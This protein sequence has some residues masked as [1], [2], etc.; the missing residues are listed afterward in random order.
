[1]L[2]F[3]NFCNNGGKMTI[4]GLKLPVL[5]QVDAIEPVNT[6]TRRPAGSFQVRQGA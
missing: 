4:P 2:L 1:M 3:G 5:S 6:T